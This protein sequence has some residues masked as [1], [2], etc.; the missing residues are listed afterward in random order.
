VGKEKRNQK[1]KHI[2]LKEKKIFPLVLIRKKIQQEAN[3]RG[4]IRG[5]SDLRSFRFFSNYPNFWTLPE[6]FRF[7]Y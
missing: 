3:T 5:I 4:N 1:G 6:P 7:L 2:K